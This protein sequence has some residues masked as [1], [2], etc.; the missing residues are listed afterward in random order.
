[1]TKHTLIIGASS[2]PARYSYLAAMRLKQ[3]NIPFSCVGVK[4]SGVFGV[5][6]HLYPWRPV[7]PVHTITLYLNPTRQTSYYQYILDLSPERVIF[8]P[9][10]ENPELQDLLT[11][12]GIEFME[13]CTLVM[14]STGAF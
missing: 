5:P 14:L 11:Q 6:I 1:M 9:G 13:A 7:N 3:R 2:N 8:N 4:D 10:T 12:K